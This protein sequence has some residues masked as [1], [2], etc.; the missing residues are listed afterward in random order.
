MVFPMKRV[1][2][3][4]KKTANQALARRKAAVEDVTMEEIF[5]EAPHR[6]ARQIKNHPDPWVPA[7]Q[8]E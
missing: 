5:H 4:V 6:D 2:P 7:A 3:L 1:E 8:D